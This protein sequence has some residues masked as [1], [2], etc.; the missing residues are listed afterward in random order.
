MN[1]LF[2]CKYNKFRSKLAE[3]FFK[4]YTD[5]HLAKS[6]GIIKGNPVDSAIKSCGNRNGIKVSGTSQNITVPLLRWQDMIVIVANDVPKSL[7]I[8]NVTVHGRKLQHWKIPDQ[9]TD[10]PEEMDEI[11]RK[12]EKKVIKLISE[13]GNKK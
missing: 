1:V 4:K 5:K 10:N 11:A 13:L 6:A 9:H 12:I 7:F 8:E 3:S 2:I